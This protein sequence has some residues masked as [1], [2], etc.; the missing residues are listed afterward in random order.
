M[1]VEHFPRSLAV[2]SNA[3]PL[4]HHPAASRVPGNLNLVAGAGRPQTNPLGAAGSSN[5][6]LYAPGAMI[7]PAA[8]GGLG[9]AGGIYTLG[10]GAFSSTATGSSGGGFLLAGPSGLVP[11]GATL[12]TNQPQSRQR[13][14]VIASNKDLL[15]DSTL[16]S[17]SQ[18]QSSND[19]GATIGSQHKNL[20]PQ[21]TPKQHQQ[22]ISPSDSDSANVA[23][24]SDLTVSLS[25]S[26]VVSN[27]QPPSE[28]KRPTSLA[29]EENDKPSSKSL[30][31]HEAKNIHPKR[32]DEIKT[33]DPTNS[34]DPAARDMKIA[35]VSQQT[36]TKTDGQIHG[37]EKAEDVDKVTCVLCQ[38]PKSPSDSTEPCKIPPTKQSSESKSHA[39]GAAELHSSAKKQRHSSHRGHIYTCFDPNC[40]AAKLRSSDSSS[41]CQ[42]S[43]CESDNHHATKCHIQ[44]QQH[45]KCHLRDSSCCRGKVAASKY[46][47][48]SLESLPTSD[49]QRPDEPRPSRKFQR[50]QSG[51]FTDKLKCPDPVTSEISPQTRSDSGS[52]DFQ[53]ARHSERKDSSDRST[54]L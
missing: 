9:L 53:A 43:K 14:N 19:S 35:S 49:Q 4:H 22:Q 40:Q 29:P 46:D 42:Q 28:P 36:E 54:I 27:S 10:G 13:M 41:C 51:D 25:A 52:T 16:S 6:A 20:Q 1:P 7:T 30:N 34:K 47:S 12:E 26:T 8:A 38:P 2:R 44:Q 32:S 37:S 45:R 5:F 48:S 17:M 15:P 23:S 21:P 50:E 18:R 11:R 39:T 24:G 33:A 31:D 3:N